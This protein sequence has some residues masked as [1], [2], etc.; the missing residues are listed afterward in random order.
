[1]LPFWI[2]IVSNLTN[3]KTNETNET[4]AKPLKRTTNN[5]SQKRIDTIQ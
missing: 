4:Q 2:T 1:M 3:N 5:I